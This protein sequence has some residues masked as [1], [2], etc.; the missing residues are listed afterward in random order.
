MTVETIA[1]G[2]FVAVIYSLSMY[3]KKA[4]NP[5]NSQTLDWY[6][7]VSTAIV[8]GLVGLVMS[9]TGTVPTEIGVETQLAVLGGLVVLSENVLKIVWRA[10]EKYTA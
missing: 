6:K 2:V 7:V 5:D 9:Q 1:M 10:I 8:G 3:L 4:L